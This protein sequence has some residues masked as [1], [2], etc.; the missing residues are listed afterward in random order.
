MYYTWIT[1]T[2]SS[3]I[4]TLFVQLLLKLRHKT[5]IV[6]RECGAIV[7]PEQVAPFVTDGCWICGA[8]KLRML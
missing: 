3:K 5:S 7:A 4:A 1:D 2:L 8:T 6:C